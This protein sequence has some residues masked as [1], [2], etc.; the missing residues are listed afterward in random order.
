MPGDLQ[1]DSNSTSW[2][3]RQSV[4][5]MG[6]LSCPVC[7]TP[8]APSPV[9]D[10][11]PRTCNVCRVSLVEWNVSNYYYLIDQGNAPPIIQVLISHLS[12][13][14][15]HEAAHELVELLRFFGVKPPLD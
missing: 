12:P 15:E 2:F 11:H 3:D 5:N 9:F 7:Q 13:L 8:F 14:T 6:Q 1:M 10:H 4:Q